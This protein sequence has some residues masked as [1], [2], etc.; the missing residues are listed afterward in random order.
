[1]VTKKL[2]ILFLIVTLSLVTKCLDDF[3]IDPQDITEIV[4]IPKTPEIAYIEDNEDIINDCHPDFPNLSIGDH[5]LEEEGF[6]LKTYKSNHKIF[7]L[8]ISDSICENCCKGE[9]LL[10]QLNQLFKASKISYKN[11]PIPIVRVDINKSRNF[12]YSEGMSFRNVPKIF[13]FQK[14]KYFE[15]DGDFDVN[16]LLH[17][18]NRHLYP[19]VLLR[20]PRELNNFLNISME[21]EEN[22]P[23]YQDEYRSIG[24]YFS[25]LNKVTRVIGMEMDKYETDEFSRTAL[26]L[27]FREDLRVAR[28]TTKQLKSAYH[29]LSN[30][31]ELNMERNS[32]VLV[33]KMRDKEYPV[34]SVYDLNTQTTPIVT[35]INQES[36]EPLEELSPESY[37]IVNTIQKPMFLVFINREHERYKEQSLELYE[38]LTYIAP[39]YPQFIFMFTED[40][41][42][43]SKKRY[44]GITWK[45][46]PAMALNHM[47]SVDTIVFPRRRP[48]TTKNI[49]QFIDDFVNGELDST[50]TTLYFENQYLELMPNVIHLNRENFSTE[51]FSKEY[52]TLLLLYD[53]YEDEQE[54]TMACKFYEKAAKRFKA[55]SIDSLKIFAYD[56]YEHSIPEE[57][58]YTQDLPQL[59]LFPASPYG[60]SGARY[61]QD[62]R[63]ERLM[64]KVQESVHIPFELPPNY[65]LSNEE[66]ARFEI[67]LPLEDL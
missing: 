31:L 6:D 59:I 7:V 33:K 9:I 21:W 3:F 44:L 56:I 4:E 29:F 40:T 64:K 15:Y 32:I 36:L 55:L 22:T 18:I 61:I 51:C 54:N 65:H 63:T 43:Y 10:G 30:D 41:E 28:I 67:G 48:F 50:G 14:G 46:E 24:P 35:W 17:F 66:I 39:N 25:S 2:H 45:E 20:T 60:N 58:G 34:A 1:M 53:A 26:Q 13:L 5:F 12:S 47:Q 19:V 49:K 38:R 42:N 37:K 62:I 52:D 8:G 27:G 11:N 57:I 16:L 23:F